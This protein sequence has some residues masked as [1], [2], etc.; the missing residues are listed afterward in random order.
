MN[1]STRIF[2]PISFG[3]VLIAF[4]LPFFTVSCPNTWLVRVSGWNLVS[5]S[6]PEINPQ[7]TKF[8]TEG[9]QGLKPKAP[10]SFP[11]SDS[12]TTASPIPGPTNLNLNMKPEAMAEKARTSKTGRVM[13]IGAFL[14]ALAGLALFFFPNEIG[15][16]AIPA[17]CAGAG[18]AA[19]LVLKAGMHPPEMAQAEMFGFRIQTEYGFWIA[20]VGFLAAVAVNLWLHQQRRAELAAVAERQFDG[21]RAPVSHAYPAFPGEEPEG[22]ERQP[23]AENGERAPREPIPV[24]GHEPV[25]KP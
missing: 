1:P 4:F 19:L 14:L 24:S 25:D 10:D 6:A 20:F 21:P 22:A 11:G 16:G 23:S 15:V 8:M 7:L 9:L 2:S 17:G 18:A 13:A 5:G 12:G 3:V